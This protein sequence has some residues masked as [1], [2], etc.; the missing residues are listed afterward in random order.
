MKLFWAHAIFVEVCTG[1]GG[2]NYAWM[3]ECLEASSA[4]MQVSVR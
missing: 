3:K 1:S 2:G 4:E